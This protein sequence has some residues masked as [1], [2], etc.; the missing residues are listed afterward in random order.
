MKVLLLT[1]DLMLDGKPVKLSF[2]PADD[3]L[4]YINTETQVPVSPEWLYKAKPAFFINASSQGYPEFIK[5]VA[6]DV[7][8]E[9]DL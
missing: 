8:Q 2:E 5:V 6:I 3:V 7:R 4:I 9:I 1:L